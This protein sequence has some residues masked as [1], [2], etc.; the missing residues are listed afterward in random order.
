MCH[1]PVILRIRIHNLYILL[2]KTLNVPIS[3]NKKKILASVDL[4]ISTLKGFS[5]MNFIA[6]KGLKSLKFFFIPTDF[7]P[8]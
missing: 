6:K 7:N 1:T 3:Y 8:Q 4:R 5:K 2:N